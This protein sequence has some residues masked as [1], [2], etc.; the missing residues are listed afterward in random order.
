M[1][2]DLNLVLRHNFFRC[3]KCLLFRFCQ[4]FMYCQDASNLLITLASWQLPSVFTFASTS[5]LLEKLQPLQRIKIENDVISRIISIFI[6]NVNTGELPTCDC[7]QY[8]GGILTVYKILNKNGVEGF[9]NIESCDANS[10]SY[11][12]TYRIKILEV[13]KEHHCK[14]DKILRNLPFDHNL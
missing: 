10:D 6:E 5:R 1:F 14:S 8:M 13:S 12:I 2:E 3:F 7:N 4:H 11:L 9:L